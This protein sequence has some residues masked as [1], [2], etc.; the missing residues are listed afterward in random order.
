MRREGGYIVTGKLLISASQSNELT[1]LIKAVRACRDMPSWS[2]TFMRCGM[3]SWND[4]ANPFL[5]A[6][7][8]AGSI[9]DASGLND[10]SNLDQLYQSQF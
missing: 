7:K 6:M 9:I 1:Y 8:S 10:I 2:K 5:G 4:I 3:K